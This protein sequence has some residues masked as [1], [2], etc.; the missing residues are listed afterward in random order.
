MSLTPNR[1]YAQYRNKPK[2]VA[3]YNIART[4]SETIFEASQAV[5]YSYRISSA[6]GEQLDVIGRI[7]VIPREYIQ[8]LDVPVIQFNGEGVYQFGQD[9]AQFSTTEMQNNGTALADDFYRL[10]ILAK[11]MRNV[12]SATIED[13]VAGLNIMIGEMD[14]VQ[15]TDNEDMTFDL[16]FRRRLTDVERS[17]IMQLAILQKPAGVKIRNIT[18]A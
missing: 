16:H 2:A 18:E 1:I 3:W 17:V 4:L 10:A 7:V 12:G 8:T 6:E 9:D 5:R 14:S 15:L 13:I 11:I